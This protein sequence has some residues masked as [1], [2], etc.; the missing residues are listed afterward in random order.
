[1]KDS[2]Q[3][4]FVVLFI[5]PNTVEQASE[6][7]SETWKCAHSYEGLGNLFATN[8]TFWDIQSLEQNKATTK[9]RHP[10]KWRH[11]FYIAYTWG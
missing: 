7:V 1:M 5:M 6:F 4:F 10:N 9:S 2:E 11:V 8:S 3:Q